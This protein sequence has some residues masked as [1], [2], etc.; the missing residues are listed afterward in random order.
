MFPIFFLFMRSVSSVFMFPYWPCQLTFNI[1]YDHF[2]TI[3]V[4]VKGAADLPGGQDASP[5]Q[6]KVE[7]IPQ[8]SPQGEIQG[9]ATAAGA[10]GSDRSRGGS[11]TAGAAGEVRELTAGSGRYIG[12]S[13][14]SGA[15]GEVRAAITGSDWS[16]G[17]GR[18]AGAAWE[19]RVA[20]TGS[21]RYRGTR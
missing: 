17:D 19:V 7:E 2:S 4:V 20:T 12:I 8:N 18:T 14:T 6:N 11:W 10:A 13:G 1:S 9:E 16:R 5:E 21:E 3:H 15:A